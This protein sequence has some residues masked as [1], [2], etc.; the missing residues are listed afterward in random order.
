MTSG[1]AF[2]AYNTEQ[3][4]YLKLARLAALYAAKY[5]PGY[6][7]C[8]IT[9]DASWKWFVESD[10]YIDDDLF[11]TIVFTDQP[12][13]DNKR[14]HKDSPYTKF[15]SAF[16][17][18][19]KHRINEFTPYDKTLLLDIDYIIQN[20]DL[21]YVF[22][23]DSSVA[24]FHNAEDL[25]GRPPHVAQQRLNDIGI[26]MLWSTVVYFDKHDEISKLFFDLW[27]HVADNYDFYRFTYGFT[28][29]MF[30]T[31]FC[32][33]IACHILNGMGAGNIIDD[34]PSPMIYM[35]QLDD[36]VSINDITDWIYLVNDRLVE[37][38]D[39]L[40]RI[41]NENVHVMNKRALERHFNDLNTK[42]GN[43]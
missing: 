18:G 22:D 4:N 28:G 29:E 7:I 6:P 23:S 37:W 12:S 25:I 30:R 16:K 36:I 8:L 42:I 27:A 11:D 15:V 43:I 24:L 1:I 26:P 9:D 19:N 32:V 2:F 3:I 13:S 14:L 21:A 35:S 33:S 41:V 20:N 40:T 5:M 38:D 39:S 31:D 10:D 34:F 17:N